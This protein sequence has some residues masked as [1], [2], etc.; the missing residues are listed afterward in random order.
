VLALL[1]SGGPRT[2]AELLER[3]GLSRAALNAHLDRL[4][5]EGLATESLGAST[6]GR[7][8]GRIAF[9]PTGGNVV[10]AW[11]GRT[12]LGL[13]VT[14]LA[15]SP[16]AVRTLE[17][18]LDDGPDAA[19][20]RVEVALDELLV[21]LAVD[22]HD[23]RGVG[24]GL[25]WP[26]EHRT[27]PHM[28]RGWHGVVLADRL[29]ARFGVPA[30]VDH[31]ARFAVLAEHRAHWPDTD[32]LLF[33]GAGS[34]LACGIISGGELQR[35]D[36]GG[37]G[38]LGHSWVS[39]AEGRPCPC[40]NAGCLETIAGGLALARRFGVADGRDVVA[41]ARAGDA[42]AGRALRDA[43]RAIGEAMA[44]AV[45]LLNPAVIVVGG[46][47]AHSDELLA[48]VREVVYQR[49]TA[50]A[51]RSLRI[52]RS[53]MGERAGLVGPA[54]AVLDL[55]LAPPA[56]DDALRKEPATT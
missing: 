48:G 21:E 9:D 54:V 47:L 10:A 32:D 16:L 19:L 17:G 29:E 39:A 15:G 35:G 25:P 40:G 14:D 43:G 56:V 44:C 36:Q 20:D 4:L 41:L 5:G 53:Q 23:V 45:N 46:D 50:H 18:G 24:V 38:E 11:L 3:T 1:R 52:L 27:L 34:A 51:T 8:A 2:R 31:Y 7:P 55:V 28:A 33:L 13:T 12:R 22:R 42:D 6:G 49:A 26:V 30:V 37:A